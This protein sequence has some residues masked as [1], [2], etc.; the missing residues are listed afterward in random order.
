MDRGTAYGALALL[1]S[2]G[3]VGFV[4]WV[5]IVSPTPE[6]AR[7]LHDE[8]CEA[9]PTSEERMHCH[10]GDFALGADR[11]CATCCAMPLSLPIALL[12]LAWA[13]HRSR[14][15]HLARDVSGA[16]A[17]RAPEDDPRG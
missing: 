15:P 13:R 17:W 1:L 7:R 12:G 14:H 10:N 9:M 11:Q 16:G 2:A 6:E 3:G 8:R 4:A 5:S